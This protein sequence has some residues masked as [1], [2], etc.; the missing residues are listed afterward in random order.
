M[1]SADV[2]RSDVPA[3]GSSSRS[4]RSATAKSSRSM[5]RRMACSAGAS[6]S[7]GAPARSSSSAASSWW[8][9]VSSSSPCAR[10][11]RPDLGRRPPAEAL[12][13]VLA[14]ARV[15]A[16]AAAVLLPGHREVP[17]TQADEQLPRAGD[18]ERLRAFGGDLVEH[19]GHLQQLA[20][21]RRQARQDLRRQ[22]AVQRVGLAADA[23]DVVGRPPRLEE[24]AGHPAAGVR[25]GARRVDA[26]PPGAL[27][28]LRRLLGR[29]RQRRLAD[30]RDAADRAAVAEVDADVRAAEQR[31]PQGRGRVAHERP[32]DGERRVVTGEP[33]ELVDH[34]QHRHAG[35]RLGEQ[36]RRLRVRDARGERVRRD[37]ARRG[38]AARERRLQVG[39]QP[40]W[41]GVRVVEREPRDRAV[42]ERRRLHHR[43]RL[44][45][46]RRRRDQDE[47]VALEQL[48]HEPADP[49]PGGE[50]LAQ[51]G[52]RQ[53]ALDHGGRHRRSSSWG[54]HR[55]TSATSPFRG[56]SRRPPAPSA[57]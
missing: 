36:P 53:L 17:G 21:G 34:Q 6:A 12:H 14:E 5:T 32:D 41:R 2:R 20:L 19:G 45:R 57:A 37:V 23:L 27:E 10:R 1:S 22:V 39:Q 55:S 51:R 56:G 54:A 33:L 38:R 31:D 7:S 42:Q 9:S 24:H 50:A 47:R 4:H 48:G 52:H 16:H 40:A 43:R 35:R 28:R 8:P 26:L 15:A 13:E 29:E 30:G 25:D 49:R 11:S 44:A 46:A 3:T 18:A